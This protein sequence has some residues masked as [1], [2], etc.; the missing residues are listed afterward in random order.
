MRAMILAAGLGTRLLPLTL[1]RPK[2]LVPLRGTSVLE[3]WTDQLFRCGFSSVV[4]N[5]Y[6][7]KEQL[8]QAVEGQSWPLPVEVHTEPV[9]LGT[10]GGIRTALESAGEEPFVVVNGDIICNAPLD[11]LNAEHLDHG[12]HVSL[13]LH[14]WPEFNNVAV[15]RD[16][17]VLGFG[18]EAKRISSDRKGV[19]L[20]AFTGIH[21]INPRALSAFPPGLPG[22]IIAIYRDLIAR[23]SPPRALFSPGV[24]WREMGSIESYMRLTAELGLMNSNFM[25]FLQTGRRVWLH[26][27][28]R[29]SPR[30]ELV[31]S[32]VVG[33]G[34]RVAEGAS[35]ENVILWE[36]V[37]VEAGSVLKDC[38]V[39]DGMIVSTNGSR[40]LR[41]AAAP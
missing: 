41:I 16:G 12:A 21:F 37:R 19:R 31:G 6:H 3:F 1:I 22:D 5:A 25:P 29:V 35:L 36:S 11:R 8:L 14:D 30:A 23:G 2:V 27:D 33:P 26:P 7:L 40:E 28:A 18:K 32:V 39:A 17:F 9:L 34:A 15:S 38:I 10:G 13:L 20:L 24:F 4:V